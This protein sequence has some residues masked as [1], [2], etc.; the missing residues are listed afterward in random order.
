[1]EC[2]RITVS[3]TVARIVIRILRFMNCFRR[4]EQ[5]LGLNQYV[6]CGTAEKQIFY[7]GT[8]AL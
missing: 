3:F 2:V 5:E 7:V 1:M 4:Y 6:N 8:S